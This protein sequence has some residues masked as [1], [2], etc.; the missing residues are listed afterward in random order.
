MCR[1]QASASDLST[2]NTFVTQKVSLA[3][4][5]DDVI[6][7]NLWFAPPPQSKILATP[8]LCVTSFVWVIAYLKT[9][10]HAVAFQAACHQ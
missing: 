5:S 9:A 3:K 4:I 2:Y 8:M 7:C 10:F 1:T 6:A